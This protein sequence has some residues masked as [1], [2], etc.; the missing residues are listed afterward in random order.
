[1]KPLYFVIFVVTVV[2]I[3]VVGGDLTS[4]MSIVVHVCLCKWL[5]FFS[6]VILGGIRASRTVQEHMEWQDICYYMQ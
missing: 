6:P 4:L 3:A 1:M 2:V 5:F